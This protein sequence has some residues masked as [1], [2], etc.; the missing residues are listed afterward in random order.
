MSNGDTDIDFYVEPSDLEC[1]D[2]RTL[3]Y[4]DAILCTIIA[5]CVCLL[6]VILGM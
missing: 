6:I 5:V 3:V 2:T 4:G 1:V